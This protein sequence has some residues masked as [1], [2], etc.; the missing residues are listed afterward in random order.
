MIS[1]DRFAFGAKLRTTFE[2]LKKSI[3]NDFVETMFQK[4][5]DYQLGDIEK[6]L[7]HILDTQKTAP[8]LV[9]I[10]EALKTTGAKRISYKGFSN[11]N[12]TEE[13]KKLYLQGFIEMVWRHYRYGEI[14]DLSFWKDD[15]EAIKMHL[16]VSE[17]GRLLNEYEEK[18]RIKNEPRTRTENHQESPTVERVEE[19]QVVHPGVATKRLSDYLGLP[20]RTHLAEK[21]V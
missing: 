3:S 17:I 19:N 16:S 9:E 2:I 18:L 20:S 10:K 4:L 11:V 8:A 14:K 7:D 6:A 1:S 5:M 13:Y 21:A 15:D 12:E